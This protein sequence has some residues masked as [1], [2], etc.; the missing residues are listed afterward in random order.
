MSHCLAQA[1][2]PVTRPGTAPR[3]HAG[4]NLNL[5]DVKTQP[6]ATWSRYVCKTLAIRVPGATVPGL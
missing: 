1:G 2:M 3:R 6:A 4:A 5:N